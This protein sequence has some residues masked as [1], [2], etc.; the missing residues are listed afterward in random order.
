MTMSQL[1][2]LQSPFPNS[3][4]GRAALN[5]NRVRC[6]RETAGLSKVQLAER[7]GV[8]SRTIANYEEEGT[9]AAQLREL[10]QALHTRPSFFTPSPSDPDIGDLSEGQVWF[11]SLRKS[12]VRQRRSAVGHGRYSLLF[13]HWIEEHFH[14]PQCDL[15]M[16]EIDSS[17]TPKQTA[18]MLR[19]DWGYGENPLP[20][21]TALAESHGIRVFSL[22][23][24]GK[25]VDAFSFVF[26]NVPYIAV[27]LQKSA[28]RIRFDIAHEIGHLVMHENSLDERTSMPSRDV[29]SEAH[30]FAA[31]LLM[32]ER[33]VKAIVPVHA[34]LRDLLAA[35]KYF[36]VSA[37]AMAR[38]AHEIG[39]LT[40]WE[41]RSM[42]SA[43]TAKGYRAGEPNGIALEQSKVFRFVAQSN[44][45]R[46]ISTT[47]IS[48]ET[49]LT[50]Q[51]L[52]ALS[53]G[54]LLAV[55]AAE[56]KPQHVEATAGQRPALSLH[57]NNEY[58]TE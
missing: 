31:N 38:C 21:M 57:V 4:Q 27:D 37:M 48:E 15:P 32:P 11:R 51:E 42:C 17:S 1:T 58:Q 53:F 45:D 8:T 24:V 3:E 26:N 13:F 20:D 50:T 29:E 12:T 14:L 9:P 39:R 55:T 6:A 36:K 10:S 28:E 49:G 33:R 19:G 7:L 46:G 23:S 25:E 30:L 5:P 47:T 40:D 44:R 41:Y 56:K 34:S 22:P 35:K 16:D 43:L 54:N 52:H 2:I 18:I